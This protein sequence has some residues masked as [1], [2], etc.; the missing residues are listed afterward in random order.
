LKTFINRI[1]FKYSTK[2]IIASVFRCIPCRS[3]KQLRDNRNLRSHYYFAKGED[4]LQDEL[5]VVTLL[6]SVRQLR[7]L[8]MALLN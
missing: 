6:K 1:R 7:L 2:D 4:K 5:D 8:T 3:R